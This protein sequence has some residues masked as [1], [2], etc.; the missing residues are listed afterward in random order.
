MRRQKAIFEKGETLFPPGPP[1]FPACPA[2]GRSVFSCPN[3]FGPG[4][5]R[6]S[7]VFPQAHSK[8]R[9][10]AMTMMISKFHKLIQ[11]RLL[12]GAF[13]VI[14]V[15]SFVVWGMVWPSDLEKAEQANA[16]G[17]LAGELVGHGE[18][19]TAYLNTYLTRALALGREIQ[20]TPESETILR[21]LSWQRLA[22]LREANRLGI[23]ATD[24]ELRGAIRANFAETNGVFDP[25]RYQAFL[26]NLIRP[27]GFST[28]QFEQHLRE[29]IQI[30][31]LGHLIGRQ[32]QVTPL[33]IRR[34][35]DTLL[36]TFAVDYV[37]VGPADVEQEV[38][39]ADADVRQLF[40]E[41]PAA[42]TIPEQREISYA[43]FPVA[44]YFD[45][46]VEIADD[47][48]QDFYELNIQDYTTT[49][50]DTN[51]QPREV[52]ADLDAVR[53]DIV[54]A[55]RRQAAFE[56]ADSAAAELAF[57]AIP[58][59][60]GTVPEFA[61]E[62]EKSGRKAQ[63]LGPFSRF[64]VPLVDG[65]AALPVATFELAPNAY[66][67]V[68]A[69]IAGT[70]NVY[71]LY[72]DKVHEPR[73]PPFDEVQDQVREVARQKALALALSAK[74]QALQEAAAAGI[75]AGKTFKQAVAGTGA[76]VQS[77]D[78]F[79]GLSGS[80]STNEIVQTL[81]QAVVSYNQ[82]E[83]TEPVPHGDGLVVAYLQTRT[84]ADPATFDSYQAEI[85]GA[86]RTRRG[87]GLFRDWQAALLAPE[88]FT[89]FQR[90]ADDAVE[91]DDADLEEETADDAEETL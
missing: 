73:V 18:F 76:K 13:L 11:S 62:A 16:A 10:T 72:L 49:E 25:A 66:D 39:V 54:A 27:L 47:D 45:E 8:E 77:A 29:E 37:F 48:V 78:S 6:R 31:K 33:E 74:G 87:Q 23:V 24:D 30:Q 12:W 40:D 80:T 52:V 75:A 19:R 69:P 64:S 70:D 91:G 71:V 81:V 4:R 28:A 67:R 3:V 7:R 1:E 55:L 68:S 59:R 34:T 88:R 90:L 46:S 32:A 86:I 60:D 35:F 26:Q 61:A 36:D 56:K 79:T 21:Q 85:A 44:D 2:G 14:I 15:F 63:K 57:R 38:Q 89:D 84:P 20:S 17:T 50:T 83:V 51:G 5:S 43:A 41:D 65:G 9:E 58:D 42:F 82:G 22:T 53:A